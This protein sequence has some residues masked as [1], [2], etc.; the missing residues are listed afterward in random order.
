MKDKL[1]EYA[2]LLHPTKED[3]E[4]GVRSILITPPTTVL[5][6]DEK[7][8]QMLI[9]RQLPADQLNNWD[10]IEVAVRTF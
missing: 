8:V 10:R 7:E 6:R 1:F 3:S 5:A 9:S 2:V 4:K